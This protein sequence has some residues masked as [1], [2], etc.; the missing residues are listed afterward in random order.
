LFNSQSTSLRL[1]LQGDFSFRCELDRDRHYGC[2]ISLTIRQIGPI[3]TDFK[4]LK[5]SGQ[6]V[7][8]SACQGGVVKTAL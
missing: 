6:R 2:P 1:R 3:V 8:N 7:A 4:G 5:N